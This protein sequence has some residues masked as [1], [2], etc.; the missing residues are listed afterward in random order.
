MDIF[1]KTLK[2]QHTTTLQRAVEIHNAFYKTR[3]PLFKEL[4]AEEYLVNLIEK[5][6]EGLNEG[7]TAQEK[8]KQ[9]QA[10]KIEQ[11]RRRVGIS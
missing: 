11:A 8:F 1:G 9:E 6:I 2:T 3:D 5:Q 4:T 7:V 10:Q